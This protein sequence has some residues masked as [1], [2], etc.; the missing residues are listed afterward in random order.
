MFS[1]LKFKL[2][3]IYSYVK[4]QR[5]LLRIS[6]KS[7]TVFLLTL[8]SFNAAAKV[9][10]LGAFNSPKGFGAVLEFVSGKNE[11]NVFSAYADMYG[12][13]EGRCA[14]PGFKIN[15]TRCK[16]LKDIELNGVNCKLYA[17]PGFTTGYARQYEP[18]YNDYRKYLSRNYGVIACLSGT[19]G[20]RFDFGSSISLDLS[21]TVEAGVHMRLDENSREFKLGLY[22][23]GLISAL[24]PQL[25]IYFGF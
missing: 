13:F 3:F 24:Y 5:I 8:V 7:I 11:T 6:P 18:Y 15:Y 1:R 9:D 2:F 19:A 23:N 14:A 10:A 16:S 20:C 21:W 17:G 12:I 4:N 22:K 25:T